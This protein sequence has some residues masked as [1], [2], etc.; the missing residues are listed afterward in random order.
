MSSLQWC[1]TARSEPMAAGECA[2]TRAESRRPV[3]S[4]LKRGANRDGTRLPCESVTAW[5]SKFGLWVRFHA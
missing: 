3:R 2:L 5:F 4:A 1:W